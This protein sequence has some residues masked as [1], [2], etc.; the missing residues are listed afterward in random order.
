MTLR[1]LELFLAL[2]KTPHLSQVA[3]ENGLTQSAVSMAI[4]TLEESLGKRLFDRINK[5]LV[6]N[7]NGR[8]FFRMVDPLVLNLKESETLFKDQDVKGDL[9]VGASSSIA[10]YIL[11]RF[12]F[13]FIEQYAGVTI[14]KITG[15]TKDVIRL[16]ERGEVD[17]GFVEGEYA[18]HHIQREILGTDE[19]Y[20]VTG[21]KDLA[22]RPEYFMEE[23]LSKR[24]ILREKGSGT[25][26]VF[27]GHLGKREKR[28]QVFQ[29]MDTTEGV[30]S[31]LTNK[32]ALSCL[33]RVSVEKELAAGQLFRLNIRELQFTRPFYTIW[34]KDKYFS[35]LLQEFIYF[36]KEQYRIKYA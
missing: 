8:F 18:S 22:Q 19:L 5:K 4:K 21:D 1:Q 32:D 29:E 15:N 28:L 10:N 35:S 24:W 11:P 26:E 13:A 17:M 30:K 27:L 12:M 3:M 7:E 14:K 25:R 36:A 9:K 23:L 2:A 34:H 6:L 33:S 16:C 31:V 20:V